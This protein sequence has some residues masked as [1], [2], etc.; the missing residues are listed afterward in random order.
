M[1]EG[2]QLAFHQ[3]P[4]WVMQECARHCPNVDSLDSENHCQMDPLRNWEA[5]P[6][7]DYAHGCGSPDPCLYVCCN[8]MSCLCSLPIICS[9]LSFGHLKTLGFLIKSMP[10]DNSEI[11]VIGKLT[12]V[13]LFLNPKLI[14][15]LSYSYR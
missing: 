7:P 4:W 8:E 1:Y 9:P 5:M 6:A 10:K 13:F 15:S 3:E 2:V 11:H 12:V 14:E